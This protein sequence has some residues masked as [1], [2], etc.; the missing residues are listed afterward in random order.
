MIRVLIFLLLLPALSGCASHRG[1]V[2]GGETSEPCPQCLG[3]NV[4]PVL[5]GLLSPDGVEMVS[6]GEAVSGGCDFN[7]P[8]SYCRVCDREFRV[9]DPEMAARTAEFAA[10]SEEMLR[11][12]GIDDQRLRQ[13]R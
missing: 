4:V 3:H 6:R 12:H 10:R 1:V 5:H 2:G 11:Q 9:P 8:T 7:G 13:R